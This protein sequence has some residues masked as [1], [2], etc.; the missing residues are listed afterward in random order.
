MLIRFYASGNN[1]PLLKFF[2]SDPNGTLPGIRLNKTA[3]PFAV[4]LPEYTPDHALTTF[5]TWSAVN[6]NAFRW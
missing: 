4:V 3:M 5:S 6:Q 1:G 2:T